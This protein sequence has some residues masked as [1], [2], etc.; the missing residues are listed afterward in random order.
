[1]HAPVATGPPEYAPL[2]GNVCMVNV[3]PERAVEE[4]V[5]WDAVVLTAALGLAVPAVLPIPCGALMTN[6]G[7]WDGAPEP[8]LC[9]P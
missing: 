8:P 7:G 6:D 9:V 5:G 1:M 3:P 2:T 4:R